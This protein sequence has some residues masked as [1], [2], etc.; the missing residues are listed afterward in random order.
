M[1]LQSAFRQSCKLHCL[2]F[3]R[4]YYFTVASKK[5][6]WQRQLG[7]N[8]GQAKEIQARRQYYLPTYTMKPS[9]RRIVENSYI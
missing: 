9:K 4:N 8:T 2:K 3:T 7:C 5:K 1:T 6:Y